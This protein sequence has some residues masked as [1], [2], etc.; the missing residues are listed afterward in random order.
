LEGHEKGHQFD[1]MD[2]L[3]VEYPR[4]SNISEE[5]T[6]EVGRFRCSYNPDTINDQLWE[7]VTNFRNREHAIDKL[8]YSATAAGVTGITG[9]RSCLACLSNTPTNMLPCRPKQHGIC[10]SCIRRY[11]PNDGEDS[12]IQIGS[13]PLG[14]S[15]TKT[16][17]SV[18]V[19]PRSAGAR[20]LALDGFVIS[21]ETGNSY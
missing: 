11:N 7:E 16:P 20:I 14:C 3:A 19:K 6:L 1:R 2:S 5:D 18:R 4:P 8:A 15:L 10:E 21:I 9:Q 17:W 12:I 13:C